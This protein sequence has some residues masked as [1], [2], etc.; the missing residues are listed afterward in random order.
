[1]DRRARVRW[2]VV[3]GV[4]LGLPLGLLL[5]RPGGAAPPPP[6][7]AALELVA[8][9][10]VS[11]VHATHAGDG[12]GRVFVVEQAGTIRIVGK[13]G[14]L[15]PRPFADLRARVRSGGEM[16]LLSVA[17]HPRYR[18]NGL[19]YVD[20]TRGGRRKLETVVAELRVDPD[21][22]DR[23]LE[24]ERVLLTVDQPYPNHNGGQLAFGPDGLLYVGLGD[25]GAAG[26]PHDH[27]ANP[28][29]LLGALLRLDVD[30][31]SDGPQGPREYAI[32]PDNPFAQGGR[33][34]PEVW[35]WGLRNP[36]RFSFD[37]GRPERLFAGDVGQNAWEEVHLVRRGDDCGWRLYEGTHK[38]DAKRPHD[39]DALAWPIHEYPRRD[40]QSIT[41]GFVY[42]G[43]RLPDLAGAYVF[44][45]Y[46]PGP[47][48][49]LREQDDGTW[50][51]EELLRRRFLL[52]SFGEDEAGELLV[53]A[54]DEGEL[55]RL[56][57]ATT[58]PH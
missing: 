3:G 24:G 7:R 50:R 25:G 29:T 20:Y 40:G 49:A 53:L 14:A 28:A 8:K 21:D 18:E 38:F 31:R 16:G 44:A 4:V 32:P 33:G 13:D 39:R 47:I 15:R 37:R 5:A 42:R 45:D 1:M 27:G 52:S 23:C 34:A 10:L 48:W 17:F 26:D 57:P 11:P 36:W 9:G 41:G 30:R 22:P 6:P 58:G 43:A 56:A 12:S 46:Y 55:H 35:A 19:L 54:H 2:G 51:R